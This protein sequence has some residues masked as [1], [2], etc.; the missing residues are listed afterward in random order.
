[1]NLIKVFFVLLLL[2]LL[3]ACTSTA[4]LNA[5]RGP[6]YVPVI[7]PKYA[8]TSV[9]HPIRTVLHAESMPCPVDLFV[10]GEHVATLEDG[11]SVELYLP[12]KNSRLSAK[13]T[14][15]C[16]KLKTKRSYTYPGLDIVDPTLYM[17]Y[18]ME[19]SGYTLKIIESMQTK[20]KLRDAKYIVSKSDSLFKGVNYQTVKIGH[21][22]E[23]FWPLYFSKSRSG[24][25]QF[26]HYEDTWSK[27]DKTSYKVYG[28]NG[29]VKKGKMTVNKILKKYPKWQDYGDGSQC[30]IRNNRYLSGFVTKLNDSF[31]YQY[32]DITDIMNSV[33]EQIKNTTSPATRQK[34]TSNQKD[35]LYLCHD[36]SLVFQQ[37]IK[38]Q[39]ESQVLAKKR[40]ISTVFGPVGEADYAPTIKQHT[41]LKFLRD[42]EKVVN[43]KPDLDA[44]E[45]YLVKNKYRM[46]KA[47][48]DRLFKT[49]FN[50]EVKRYSYDRMLALSKR[51]K[52]TKSRFDKHILSHF[53]NNGFLFPNIREVEKL[54]GKK[55]TETLVTNLAKSN[56][57]RDDFSYLFNQS[58]YVRAFLTGAFQNE[59]FRQHRNIEQFYTSQAYEK[60][61]RFFDVTAKIFGSGNN[62][63]V[64]L[65]YS[66]STVQF[67]LPADCTYKKSDSKK[68]STGFFEGILSGF[69]TD[70]LISYD[71][72]SC[73]PKSESIR[74][75][76]KLTS[77]VNSISLETN[78]LNRLKWE[79]VRVTDTFYYSEAQTT[80]TTMPSSSTGNTTSTYSN[81]A[82]VRDSSKSSSRS[83]SGLKE[84]YNGGYKSSQGNIMYIVKCNSGRSVSAFKDN[85]GW[86]KDSGGSKMGERYRNLSPQDFGEKY[87][88]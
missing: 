71:L 40:Y 47:Q 52:I 77:S 78:S 69:S 19:N 72:Y 46:S 14:G 8:T 43:K 76:T 21:P 10:A 35:V 51:L 32:A 23:R 30:V 39:T 17:G 66:P 70:K 84:V 15:T 59:R 79:D 73:K 37:I 16:G 41:H 62:L 81:N 26:V 42:F 29:L 13:G 82:S 57:F 50:Q 75:I 88:R 64:S 56:P 83:T 24:Q 87:C 65:P 20:V 85:S 25:L 2:N 63:V 12:A 86:W 22:Y 74:Q 49:A 58:L 18:L 31:L 7:S 67:S 68:A 80:N 28:P 45:K 55:A 5:P 3:Q 53:T 1:M 33:H 34:Y 36:S 6:V 4:Y 54:V 11:D 38:T 48:I 60:V 44:V 9:E 27:D 61:L